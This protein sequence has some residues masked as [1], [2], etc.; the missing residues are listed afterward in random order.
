MFTT[1]TFDEL[2]TEALNR[3]PR[4]PQTQRIHGF[5]KG[6]FC[7]DRYLMVR[8]YHRPIHMT[9]KS[10]QAGRPIIEEVEYVMVGVPADPGLKIDVPAT[11]EHKA[12]FPLDYKRFK[13]GLGDEETGTRLTNWKGVNRSQ[14]Y[15]LGALNI[16]TVEQ[17]ANLSD[18]V[19]SNHPGMSLLREKANAHLKQSQEDFIT[20]K[21]LAN[22]KRAADAEAAL[23]TATQRI[24]AMEAQLAKL[25]GVEVK[26]AKK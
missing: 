8:F 15:E 6:E 10:K 3:E 19:C 1:P 4:D 18:G 21:E 16:H 13:D 25:A 26:A 24:A 5:T 20:A 7:D 17:L 22:E 14:V 9:E 12:R 2:Q 23:A 11:D